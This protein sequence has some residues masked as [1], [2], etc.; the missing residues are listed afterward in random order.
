MF[1]GIGEHMAFFL[2]FVEQNIRLPHYK[3]DNITEILPYEIKGYILL[4]GEMDV[5]FTFDI[6]KLY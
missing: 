2:F 1:Y 4:H 3:V 5:P 6:L